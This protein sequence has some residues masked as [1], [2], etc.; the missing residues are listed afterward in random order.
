MRSPSI[1]S[2]LLL[3]LFPVLAACS[4]DESTFVP[5]TSATGGSAGSSAGSAGDGGAAG[6]GGAAAGSAGNG[7]NA[8]DGGSAGNAGAAGDG[9]SA[10]DSGAAGEAGAGDGGNAGQ[11][12]AGAAGG[13]AAGQA[14]AGGAASC[15]PPGAHA[16]VLT[17][18]AASPLCVARVH[19][20]P[21][22]SLG[23]AFSANW[24]RH[25]GPL[26]T[27]TTSGAEVRRWEVPGDPQG[28]ITS[29]AAVKVEVEKI[30]VGSFFGPAID[31]PFHDWTVLTYTTAPP[32][33]EGEVIALNGA[34]TAVQARSPVNGWFSAAALPGSKQRLLF[35]GL[36]PVL[37]APGSGA[38]SGLF[39]VDPCDATA[40]VK[41][42]CGA[43]GKLGGWESNS[44]PV[45]TDEAG[46]LFAA[47]S[48]F[49]GK[50]EVR[51]FLPSEA[52][53]SVLVV[54]QTILSDSDF[55]TSL[56]ALGDPDGQG[57]LLV[58]QASDSTTFGAKP[59]QLFSYE[60][61]SGGL[62]ST[63]VVDGGFT[64]K[65]AGAA[66]QVFAGSDGHLW[67]AVDGEDG[68]Y[69]VALVRKLNAEGWRP[70]AS[71]GAS[72]RPRRRVGCGWGGGPPG[73]PRGRSRARWPPRRGS[74]LRAPR[75]GS[76]PGRSPGQRC[77]PGWS[78]R[79]P[80]PT[81]PRRTTRKSGFA[82]VAY[83]PS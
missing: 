16:K 47:A 22:A 62:T 42:G 38:D 31:V 32:A 70:R 64:A 37:T 63:A 80:P 2:T 12:G 9:G 49:G 6:S 28:P 43:S 79:A 19:K 3:L 35:T 1:S 61:G 36:S 69:F 56:A 57:G 10:G 54:G 55:S 27:D 4:D 59:A 51:G 67:V 8:G 53:G 24:G 60:V 29:G 75:G 14:G 81:P 30:P 46:H 74:D 25:G 41:P 73:P 21:L 48:T 17:L 76:L 58:V 23:F 13:G 5:P 18:G 66:P 83:P 7:G 11:G 77:R 45:A 78:R 34:L 20:T 15:L 71:R 26:S 40:I 65:V 50:Q 72:R 39:Y 68:A 44:G 82:S 52:A 33:F